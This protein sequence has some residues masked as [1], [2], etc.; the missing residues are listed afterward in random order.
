VSETLHRAKPP[1]ALALASSPPRAA[2][3]VPSSRQRMLALLAVG[4]ATVVWGTGYLFTHLALPEVRPFTLASLRLLLAAL[5][6]APL[7]LRDARRAPRP[8][9]VPYR[10]LIAMG[11][12]GVALFYAGFNAGLL[13]AP[14]IEIGLIFAMSPA[15]TALMAV[16]FLHEQ[17][18]P[19]RWLGIALSV[20]GVAFITL[21]GSGGSGASPLLGGVLGMLAVLGWS[22][23]V[24]IGK[25]LDPRLPQ[26]IVTAVVTAAGVALLLPFS[27]AE[28]LAGQQGAISLGGWLL[29][30][31]L[32]LANSGL[33]Y[34]LFNLGL[35]YLGASEAQTILQLNTVVAV[36]AGVVVLG[37]PLTWIEAAG[38]LAVGVGVWLATR[39]CWRAFS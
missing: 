21:A 26:T 33:A 27:A 30:G 17:I 11:F 15:A 28:V 31:Y 9:R 14:T 12:S 25:Y 36:L 13:Y 35:R 5:A 10:P 24:T 2:T 22:T 32:A 38:G 23:Y 29:I 4:A 39:A 1:A 6:L 7:A 34:H 37:E 19:L 8:L 3:H 16:L 18:S 20:L